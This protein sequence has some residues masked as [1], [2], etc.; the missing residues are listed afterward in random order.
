IEPHKTPSKRLFTVHLEKA[1]VHV[2]WPLLVRAGLDGER[3]VAR[4]DAA[5]ERIETS[6]SAA[7]PRPPI[8]DDGDDCGGD[9]DLDPT[10]EFE[11]A[12]L[13][14]STSPDIAMRHVLRSA[15]GGHVPAMLRAAAFYELGG[16]DEDGRKMRVPVERDAR[17]AFLWH[18]RAADTG[19]PEACYV[20]AT[21]LLAP[22]PATEGAGEHAATPP[23]SPSEVAG[24]EKAPPEIVNAAALAY[25]R[26]AVSA[27]GPDAR[28]YTSAAFQ[29]GLVAL[30]GGNGLPNEGDPREARD[31]WILSAAGGHPLSC[32]NLG[33]LAVTGAVGAGGEGGVEPPPAAG[34]G[35]IET[36]KE[37]FRK[38]LE[39]DHTLKIPPGFEA[40][41]GDVWEAAKRK[42]DVA[43]AG[44]INKRRLK[45]KKKKKKEAAAGKRTAREGRKQPGASVSPSVWLGVSALA[46]AICVGLWVWKR[47]S[48]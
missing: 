42:R 22:A 41:V 38:A 45:K 9:P 14:E 36:A 40:I 11:L 25:F 27:G 18:K 35:D 20:V 1:S 8:D 43:A 5:V 39:L 6:A 30:R 23:A 28:Y 24:A 47:K 32:W 34:A 46:V 3:G 29:A 26:R 12:K 31:F 37:W 19:D 10:S 17:K 4:R 16:D 2:Q 33:V 15:A 21:A 48:T 13:H 7:T 44:E